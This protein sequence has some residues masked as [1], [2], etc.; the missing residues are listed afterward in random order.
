MTILHTHFYSLLY[1]PKKQLG[2]PNQ[3]RQQYGR[4]IEIKRNLR[5]KKLHRRI[6]FLGDRFNN[7]DYARALIQL[8][9]QRQTQP[10]KMSFLFKSKTIHLPIQSRQRQNKD[11]QLTKNSINIEFVKKTNMLH[12]VESLGYIKCHSSS[13][14]RPITASSNSIKSNCQQ[15]FS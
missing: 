11:K 3:I 15:V 1:L 9:R 6:N 8:R 5:R 14:P 12:F 4:F 10:L 13:I 7:R 2:A